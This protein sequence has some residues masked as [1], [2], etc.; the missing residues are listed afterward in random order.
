MTSSTDEAMAVLK[1]K[2]KRLI[3]GGRIVGAELIEENGTVHSREVLAEMDR[4]GLLAGT[5]GIKDFWLGA[6]FHGKE[7]NEDYEPTGEYFSYSDTR[8]R[9]NG[10]KR[11]IHQRTVQVWGK[12][13]D[14]E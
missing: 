9:P 5:E 4:Q 14:A 10:K 1:A 6:V 11:N 13:K 12:R 8:T 3:D 2:R 7:W